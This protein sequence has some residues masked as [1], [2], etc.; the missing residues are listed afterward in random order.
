MSSLSL[1]L[2]T[3]TAQILQKNATFIGSWKL[4]LSY[5]ILIEL[6]EEEQGKTGIFYTRVALKTLHFFQNL[7]LGFVEFS[8]SDFFLVFNY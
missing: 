8:L 1:A 4:P 7:L 5:D 6:E 3:L 2:S